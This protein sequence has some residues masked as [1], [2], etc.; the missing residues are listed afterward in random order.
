M[1][2]GGRARKANVGRGGGPSTD[3]GGKEPKARSAALA[4]R[5][6]SRARTRRAR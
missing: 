4:R 6:G 1:D 3:S 5:G 2:M